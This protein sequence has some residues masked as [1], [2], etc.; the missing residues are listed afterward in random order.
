MKRESKLVMVNARK[1][2]G[3]NLI[4]VMVAVLVLSVGLLGMGALMG[5]SIRYTQSANFR[6]QATNLAY[7]Y[8]DM[9]RSNITN[10]GYYNVDSYTDPAACASPEVPTN[11]TTCGSVHDCDRARW[12]RDLCYALPNGRGQ[13]TIARG[14]GTDPLDFDITVAVCWSD[15]RGEEAE[16]PSADCSNPNETRFVVASGL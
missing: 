3:L 15:D 7:D 6:T 11:F 10:M 13:A 2:R 1:Q 9:V 4:E 5:V 12:A 14:A 16:A 8:I